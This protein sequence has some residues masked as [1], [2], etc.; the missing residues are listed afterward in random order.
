M[1]CTK[2]YLLDDEGE[3]EV[4]SEYQ[5]GVRKHGISGVPY[6]IVSREGSEAEMTLSGGQPPAVFLDVFDRLSSPS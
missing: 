6:F 5:N 3:K 2:E 1:E 4:V